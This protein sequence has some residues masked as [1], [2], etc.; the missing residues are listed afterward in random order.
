M[1]VVHASPD[2]PNVDVAV[3]GGA[4]VVSN[5][6]YPNATATYLELAAGTYPLEIRATG[7]SSAVFSFSTPAL[8]A[9]KVYTVFA[10]GRLGTAGEFGVVAVADAAQ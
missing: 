8:E 9:S 2:A 6:A 1:R 3:Q 10:V 5:L 4:V 7:S